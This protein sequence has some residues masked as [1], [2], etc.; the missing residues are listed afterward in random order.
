[1]S[2]P[3]GAVSLW[4][5]LGKTNEA[6]LD[7][8]RSAPVTYT[9]GQESGS[10]WNIDRY[11]TILG[12]DPTGELFERA[13]FLALR[14][15]FYPH[16]IMATASDFQAEGRSVQPGDRLLQRI[17]LL[18]FWDKPL[19]ERVVVCEV[20]EVVDEPRRKGFTA[21]TTTVHDEVGDWSPS[22]V[23]RENGE[24]ALI[25]EVVSR[26]RSGVSALYG[27]IFRWLQLRAHKL[28]LEYF[29][30]LVRGE[31]V[32]QQ[33]HAEFVPP[34]LLP[35]GFLTLAAFLFYLWKSDRI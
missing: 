4:F 34:A 33:V 9:S 26:C 3:G 22:I 2:I 32:K 27:Q 11:E 31:R 10:G 1:M 14:N 8:W 19:V 35:V 29:Q 23:W 15:R 13:A 12:R 18:Q 6:Y 20:T 25:I 21:T 28:T 17:R 16:Q 7:E 5:G 30:R 24:V